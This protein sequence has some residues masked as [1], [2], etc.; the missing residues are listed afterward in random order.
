M[1]HFLLI[2]SPVSF[3]QQVNV[4]RR[5]C[6]G[7]RG[8]Q[9]S[10]LS[11]PLG[12][13][14]TTVS[15]QALS[16]I[17]CDHVLLCRLDIRPDNNTRPRYCSLIITIWGAVLQLKTLSV[18]ASSQTVLTCWIIPIN[19]FLWPTRCEAARE[20][21]LDAAVVRCTSDKYCVY[22]F[23]ISFRSFFHHHL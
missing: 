14:D 19:S 23:I 18:S 12:V 8:L 22:L 2:F 20:G 1:V 13:C 15:L 5:E 11:T 9:R 6:V 17:C 21:S 4:D 10:R 3:P 7:V 16:L